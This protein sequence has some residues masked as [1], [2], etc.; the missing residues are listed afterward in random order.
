MSRPPHDHRGRRAAARGLV[1]AEGASHLLVTDPLNVR[2]LTGF[3]GSNGQCLLGPDAAADRLLTDPRYVERAATEAP[4]LERVIDRDALGA[5]LPHVGR[6]AGS[7]GVLA[8]EASHVTWRFAERTQER[9]G[10]AGV[11]VIGMDGPIERLRRVKDEAE[12]ARIA[13]ACD[14]TQRCLAWLFEETVA[15]GMTERRLAVLLERRFI[16]EGADDVGFPSI[17]ASGPNSAIPHHEPGDREVASGDLLTVDC[18]A[19]IDGYRADHTRTVAIGAVGEDLA[20]VHE[21]VC[22]AQSAAM[23]GVRVGATGGEVD[24][25]ARAVVGSAGFGQRF[26]HGTG[27]G[28]GLAVHEAPPVGEGSAAILAAGMVLTVEPGIYLPGIGGVRIEDTLVVT[29][30]AGGRALTD[31]PR[32]LRIL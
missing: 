4:D 19:S 25:A 23:A 1:A 17:V 21:V 5:V 15:V 3:T 18:G 16:D 32:A 28:I 8:L 30:D 26:V 20:H 14:I 7:E 10:S 11:A 24:A 2:Y 12:L 29:A 13:E 6:D 22:R 31:T 9:A 27:H